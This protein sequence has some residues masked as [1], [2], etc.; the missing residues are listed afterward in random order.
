MSPLGRYRTRSPVRY[1]RALGSAVKLLGENRSAVRSGRLKY[2]RAS[3]S[4]ARC[5]SPKTPI[6]T[7]RHFL[8]RTYA[9]VFEIGRPMLTSPLRDTSVYVE[10]V[11]SSVGPYRL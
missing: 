6:G 8:S 3:P 9:W 7:G 10:Y 4:P 1:M 11:V 5:N 2:P